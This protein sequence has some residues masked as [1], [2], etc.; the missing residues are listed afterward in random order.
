MIIRS[1]HCIALAAVCL[2]F[3]AAAGCH[4]TGPPVKMSALKP[5]KTQVAFFERPAA[6]AAARASATPSP[7][8]VLLS[9]D[10]W[11]MVIGSDSPTFALYSDGTVIFQQKDGYR[12]IKLTQIAM[13]E[14][15]KPLA[16][17]EL[18]QLSGRFEATS[19]TD[20]PDNHLL[21]YNQK[22]PFYI[23]VYGSL[24]DDTV[25]S[26]VPDVVLSAFDRLRN[27]TVPSAQHWLPTRVE[28]MVWPYEYAPD[29][30]IIWPKKWPTLKS[31]TTRKRGDSYSIFVPSSELPAL[32]S[33][34]ASGRQKGAVE[35]DRKKWAASIRL[36][37]PHEELWMSPN[38]EITAKK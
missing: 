8:V 28:V 27:F 6:L 34:L 32:K 11:R 20:Q 33:F 25:R 9:T 37:F 18:A 12:S 17:P 4:D 19:W 31:P 2:L 26:K 23:S 7:V 36:P 16:R 1:L 38:E 30:S 14:M 29:P 21:V 15:L 10:P 24:N 3:G 5:D 35:I 13:D 22:M